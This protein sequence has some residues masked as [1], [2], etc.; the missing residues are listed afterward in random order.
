MVM[1]A[2]E[3]ICLVPFGII[4]TFSQVNYGMKWPELLL[5]DFVR[6]MSVEKS[7]KYSK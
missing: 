2:V 4:L 6:E 3:L 7:C 5:F 1:V